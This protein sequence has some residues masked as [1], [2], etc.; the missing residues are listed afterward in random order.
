[1]LRGSLLVLC[2]VD[3]AQKLLLEHCQRLAGGSLSLNAQ[4]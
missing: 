3:M 1:M 2:S 4:V